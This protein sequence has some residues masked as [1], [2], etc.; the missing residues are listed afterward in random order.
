MPNRT[1]VGFAVLIDAARVVDV[2]IAHRVR[3]AARMATQAVPE[4]WLPVGDC[5]GPGD[6]SRH[7]ARVRDRLLEAV[8]Y[9]AE[10]AWV[11]DAPR[12]SFLE[13][14]NA[15]RVAGRGASSMRSIT[16]RWWRA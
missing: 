1:A 7:A 15:L 13:R 3:G 12:E 14:W 5:A 10:V 9:V 2:G 4:P 6:R 11:L 8:E 16:R